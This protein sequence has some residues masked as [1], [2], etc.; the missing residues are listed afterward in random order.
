MKT[1]HAPKAKVH[2]FQGMISTSAKMVRFFETVKRVA[3]TDSAILIRGQ[4]GT[5]KELVARAIHN[6]SP[7][8]AKTFNAVNC[9]VLTP[10]LATSEL[11]GHIKGSFTGAVSDHQG[12][13]EDS[14]KGTLFLDEVAELPLQA[15]SRLLRVI[16]EKTMTRLGSTK[17]RSVDVRILSAT[18]KALRQ[19]TRLGQ[20]REDLMYR[21]RVVPI[22]LP[23]LVERGRDIEVLAWRFID[24]F[25]QRATRQVKALSQDARDALLNYEWP[26]NVR[27][28]RNNIENA[29][30]VGIGDVLQLEDL[31]P[32]LRGEE[33][34]APGSQELTLDYSKA[35]RNRI[36][37]ALNAAEGN[38]GAAADA[39]GMSRS[40]LWRK[41]KTMGLS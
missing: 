25:N 21:L 32:E 27:E 7:R 30:A 35:E 8:S 37:A 6:L 15:Q 3:Q 10:E 19:E 14:H 29:F 20:F 38:K 41:M 11:F 24:E 1:F 33:P 39:L 22:Y 26:G 40:T 5:G 12:Y 4:S 36:V 31:T 28:L 18:H 23:R 13:F 34:F 17:A 9:A 16:Q 2:T